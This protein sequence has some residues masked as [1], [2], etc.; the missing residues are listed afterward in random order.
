M[1]FFS[2]YDILYLVVLDFHLVIYFLN[3]CSDEIVS[4]L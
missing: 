2:F 3:D 1:I 4:L